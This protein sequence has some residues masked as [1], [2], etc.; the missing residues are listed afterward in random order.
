MCQAVDFETVDFKTFDGFAAA[1]RRREPPTTLLTRPFRAMQKP[2]K[3]QGLPDSTD[4]TSPTKM[5]LCGRF[6]QNRS[7]V[8]ILVQLPELCDEKSE[9]FEAGYK[10]IADISKERIRRVIKK[11][12]EETVEVAEQEVEEKPKKK[13]VKKTTASESKPAKAKSS[14]ATKTTR[15]KK[16]D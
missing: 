11:I 4:W 9:A 16:D 15:K 1:P 2:A 5:L 6:A 10:T 13:A 14:S 7:Q 8:L 12:E 3:I